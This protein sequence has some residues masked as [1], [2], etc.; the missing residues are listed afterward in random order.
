MYFLYMIKNSY[1]NLYLGVTDNPERRLAEH[2]SK[3]GSDFTKIR[4]EFH[5]VFL[6]KHNTLTEARQREIQLKK[7][8]RKKKEFLIERYKNGLETKMPSK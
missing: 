8:G 3:R 7:W 2:N 1:G 4:D 5:I 6:E